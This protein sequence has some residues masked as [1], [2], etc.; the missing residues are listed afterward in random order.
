MDD[1]K[2]DELLTRL[3]DLG[4][5]TAQLTRAAALDLVDLQ[6]LVEAIERWPWLLQAPR[7]S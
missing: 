4:A 6:H 1:T 7:G 2:R 3:A 5:T